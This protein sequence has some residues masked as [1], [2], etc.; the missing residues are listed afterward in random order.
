MSINPI[1]A[2]LFDFGGVL[3]DEG[4]RAGL[5][6]IAEQNRLD[7]KS[8]QDEGFRQVFELGFVTG[9]IREDLFWNKFR[10]S[11]D[12]GGTDTELTEIVLSRFTLRP[13][14]LDIVSNLKNKG[15]VTGILSDQTHWLSEMNEK[16]DFFPLFDYVFNSY[17][18]GISKKNPAIFKRVLKKMNINP[19]ETIFIDDH[20]ANIERAREQGLHGI[21]YKE[22]EIFIKDIHSYIPEI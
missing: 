3:A 18:L 19:E 8:V 4:F 9:K 1:K 20:P 10:E 2:V 21:L 16:H 15:F 7:V 5:A 6:Y 22:K 11:L 17:Y 12:I 14:M 13:W